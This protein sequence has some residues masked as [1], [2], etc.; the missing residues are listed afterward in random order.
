[1][2]VWLA[3]SSDK[4]NCMINTNSSVGIAGQRVLFD[5]DD[6]KNNIPL[7]SSEDS[8]T[9][10]SMNKK[11]TKLIV[12]IKQNLWTFILGFVLLVAAIA[13]FIYFDPFDWFPFQK[14]SISIDITPVPADASLP[15]RVELLEKNQQTIV[16]EVEKNSEKLSKHDEVLIM[17]AKTDDQQNERI[18]KVEKKVDVAPPKNVVTNVE[19]KVDNVVSSSASS[20][21]ST[22]SSVSSYNSGVSA[23]KNSLDMNMYVAVY[24]DWIGA[25]IVELKPGESLKPGFDLGDGKTLKT[26]AHLTPFSLYNNGI[27]YN[28]SDIF[29]NGKP[30][31]THLATYYWAA[32]TP[33]TGKAHY[34]KA[35][36][37]LCADGLF[38]DGYKVTE[39]MGKDQVCVAVDLLA[40]GGRVP[41]LLM[42]Y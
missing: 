14:T 9:G 1:M 29:L 22:S 24:G 19:K 17:L 18:E 30:N 3:P 34:N 40:G 28:L 15:E 7:P 5:L 23:I 16:S 31:K 39:L 37:I 33:I 12:V 4:E 36:I 41:T 38:R 32:G 25:K 8:K 35:M 6:G 21:K 11:P 26:G 13:A 27:T 20:I 2:E 42:R 10:G